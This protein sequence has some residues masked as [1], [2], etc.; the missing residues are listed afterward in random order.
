MILSLGAQCRLK[1]VYC[2]WLQKHFLTVTSCFSSIKNHQIGVVQRVNLSSV[3]R[4]LLGDSSKSPLKLVFTLPTFLRT[5]TWLDGTFVGFLQT[6]P[7]TRFLHHTIGSFSGRAVKGLVFIREVQKEVKGHDRRPPLPWIT[8]DV[9]PAS[10]AGAGRRAVLPLGILQKALVRLAP[11]LLSFVEHRPAEWF[12]PENMAGYLKV[13][14]SLSRS[15]ATLSRNPAV[16]APA[17]TNCQAQRNCEWRLISGGILS[18]FRL[19]LAAVSSRER[20]VLVSF[21]IWP[22]CDSTSRPLEVCRAA[23][24]S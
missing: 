10:P 20:C 24:R 17:A 14:S 18:I 1:L 9:I 12:L 13:L 8:S 7:H 11:S 19:T 3:H 5:V 15:A 23:P 6:G 16:L 4:Q 21:T 22:G 2:Y